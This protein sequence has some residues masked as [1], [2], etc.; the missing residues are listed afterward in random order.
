[1]IYMSPDKQDHGGENSGIMLD[2]L[3]F[4]Y[5][6][7]LCLSRGIFKKKNLNF[8]LEIGR[9]SDI[10]IAWNTIKNSNLIFTARHVIV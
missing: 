7:D 10:M 4:V 8:L 5:Q 2:C 6:R 3:N 1:M 9:K